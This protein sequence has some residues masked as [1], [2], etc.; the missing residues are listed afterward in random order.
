MTWE[1]KQ[2]QV[3]W[4]ELFYG[5]RSRCTSWE[6]KFLFLKL[7]LHKELVDSKQMLLNSALPR[8]NKLKMLHFG[9]K[10]GHHVVAGLMILRGSGIVGISGEKSVTHCNNWLT[11][12]SQMSSGNTQ[13]QHL[14]YVKNNPFKCVQMWT[15]F[16]SLSEFPDQHSR[17]S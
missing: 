4:E 14:W 6:S 2:F 8:E 3:T 10:S 17:L 16:V 5:Y 11:S 15:G 7:W 9:S 1:G 12:N 13:L